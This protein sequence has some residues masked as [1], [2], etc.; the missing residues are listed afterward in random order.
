MSDEAKNALA[1]ASSLRKLFQSAAI[2]GGF[3]YNLRVQR[4]LSWEGVQFLRALKERKIYLD[5]AESWEEFCPEFLGASYKTFDRQLQ[6]AGTRGKDY[7]DLIE[8]A[9][10]QG[11]NGVYEALNVVDGCIHVNGNKIEIK[12][13][14]EAEINEVIRRLKKEAAQAKADVASLEGKAETLQRQKDEAKAA[15]KKAKEELQERIDREKNP[16][17]LADEDYSVM[18]DIESQFDV[19][20]LRLTSVAERE[21]SRENQERLVALCESMWARTH[22]ATEKIRSNYG[23]GLLVERPSAWMEVDELTPNKKSL[24]AEYVANEMKRK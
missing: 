15:A 18:L 24:T 7:F 19:L 13:E 11:V 12:R 2:A 14:N 9:P 4:S 3:L 5:Y 21:L 10:V 6:L 8:L 17:K 1:K 23:I 20:I 22:Q 16:W